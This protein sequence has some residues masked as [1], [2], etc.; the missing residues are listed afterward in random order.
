MTDKE[1]LEKLLDKQKEDLFN[2]DRDKE[3]RKFEAGD[4]YRKGI[5]HGLYLAVS[6]TMIEL[7]GIGK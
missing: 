7:S 2:A 1:V 5:S 4:E 6:R 3:L